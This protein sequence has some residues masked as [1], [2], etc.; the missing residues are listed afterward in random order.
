MIKFVNFAEI[1][2]I[3]ILAGYQVNEGFPQRFI[4]RRIG[5]NKQPCPLLIMTTDS[6]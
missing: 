3:K 4:F 6:S 2:L 5:R 1:A